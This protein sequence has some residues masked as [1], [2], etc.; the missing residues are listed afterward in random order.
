M[1]Y[2]VFK[3]Q[4]WQPNPDWPNGFE[5]L[6]A[7]PGNTLAVCHSREE[8]IEFCEDRNYKW[9]RY[10]DRVREGLATD[11]QANTYFTADRYEWTEA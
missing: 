4:V 5:P 8:A 6:A 1:S 2:R 7:P 9:R 10:S 3:R 11:T